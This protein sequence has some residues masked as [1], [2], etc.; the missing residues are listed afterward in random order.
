MSRRAGRVKKSG[1]SSTVHSED[2]RCFGSIPERTKPKGA[3]N[4]AKD[5]LQALHLMRQLAILVGDNR[6]V[7]LGH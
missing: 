6:V 5:N 1:E 4:T 3:T 2:L 7:I